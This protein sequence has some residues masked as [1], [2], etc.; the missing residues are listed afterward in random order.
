ME[1][2]RNRISTKLTLVGNQLLAVRLRAPPGC[3]WHWPPVWF[4]S[5]RTG[6]AYRK[7]PQKAA[8]A[9]RWPGT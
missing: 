9:G 6:E 8:A 4:P 5:G 2:G 1:S 3:I 7:T